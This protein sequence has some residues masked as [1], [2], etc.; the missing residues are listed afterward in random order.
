MLFNNCGHNTFS[1][2]HPSMFEYLSTNLTEMQNISQYE[3]NIVLLYRT[4]AIYDDVIR[5]WA[6]CA[7]TE[8]CIAPTDKLACHF[9]TK[10]SYADCHRF[11]QSALNILL[12]NRFNFEFKRYAHF[13]NGLEKVSRYSAGQET[14]QYCRQ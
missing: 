3:A 10:S 8:A 6:L 7:L 12:A 1:V 4:R 9:T 5:W 2:T 11:D 13:V 14:S